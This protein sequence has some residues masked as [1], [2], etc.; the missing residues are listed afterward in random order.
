LPPGVERLNELAAYF[1]IKWPTDYLQFI[2]RYNGGE[3]V[4]ANISVGKA[5]R[6]IEFFL[7]ILD[8][9]KDPNLPGWRDLDVV[10]ST[11]DER[12]TE[13]ENE[14]GNKVLP[15]AAIF[16]G[17]FICLDFR[18]NTA[19]PGIVLWEH[20]RSISFKPSYIFVANTFDEFL[21]QIT[22]DTEV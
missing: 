17:D 1:G 9:F 21:E 11:L 7:P 14:T 8:D 4:S 16:A 19:S 12:L 18:N 3:P 10:I 22:V 6:A 2:S 20:E 13:D 5:I 15:I